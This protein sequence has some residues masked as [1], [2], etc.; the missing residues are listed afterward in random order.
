VKRR[1]NPMLDFKSFENAHV[2]IAGIEFAQKILKKQSA[3][4]VLLKRATLKCGSE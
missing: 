2:V 3:Q 4:V 1:V